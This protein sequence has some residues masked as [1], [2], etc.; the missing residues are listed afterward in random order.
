MTTETLS[1]PTQSAVRSSESSSRTIAV[2]GASGLVGSAFVQS[3]SGADDRVLNVTRSLDARSSDDIIWS[4]NR[5]I[6]NPARLEG[7]DAFVHLAGE[8]IAAGRWTDTKKSRIRNSRVEGTR[9]IASTLARLEQKPSVLVCASAIGFYGDRGSRILDESAGAGAGFLADV[10]RDWEAATQ[11]AEHAGI[12]I[13][14]LRIGV[15]ISR[16]GGALPQMLTP[17]KM[18]VGGRIGSGRQFWSWV[19]IDD[20][21]GAIQSVIDD[22]T[23]RGAVNCVAPE[24]VTNNDF[25]KTLGSVLGRP[26]VFPMPGFVAR[27]ALGQMAN[28]LL[29]SSTRVLPRRLQTSGYSFRQP[30]LARALE[31]EINASDNLCPA[32]VQ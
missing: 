20:V 2:S 30:E 13:V 31:S 8:N 26:T 5:G 25:T 23:I 14:H 12:R 11:P 7:T 16:H 21:V 29:L 28:D 18:G 4:P 22:K 24:P 9:L 1:P 19:S 15:V 10:C 32:C 6:A 27:L 17:F 3:L